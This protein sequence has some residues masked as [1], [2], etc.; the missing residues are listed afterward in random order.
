[1][2]LFLLRMMAA[3]SSWQ[4]VISGVRLQSQGAHSWKECPFGLRM[5]F[6]LFFHWLWEYWLLNWSWLFVF[7]HFDQSFM[8]CKNPQLRGFYL[9]GDKFNCTDIT[10]MEQSKA[11]VKCFLLY[12]I[13]HIHFSVGTKACAGHTPSD[14]SSAKRIHRMC[15]NFEKF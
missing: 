10:M 5:S 7:F 13:H 15:N 2:F 14:H 4:P 6:L 3:S 9:L 11:E 1:M 12:A 8:E